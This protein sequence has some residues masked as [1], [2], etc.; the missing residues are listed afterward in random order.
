MPPQLYRVWLLHDGMDYEAV[1]VAAWDENDAG[2][3]AQRELVRRSGLDW[4]ID[5]V[6]WIPSLVTRPAVKR[7]GGIRQVVV[8]ARL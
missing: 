5:R 2:Q 8:A 7:V 1:K 6:D 4:T 3:R